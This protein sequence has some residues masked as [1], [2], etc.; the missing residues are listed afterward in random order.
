MIGNFVKALGMMYLR[1]RGLFLAVVLMAVDQVSKA[2][3]V[4]MAQSRALPVVLHHFLNLV[5]VINR[6]IS[7]GI[8]AHME[9]WMSMVL[10]VG[11]S[12]IALGLTCWLMRAR[13]ATLIFGLAFVIGGALG[14]IVDRIRFGFVIDFLDFH[15]GEYHY[16][17]FNIADSFIFMGVVILL[18]LSIVKPQTAL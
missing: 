9:S 11:T 2:A 15:W 18:L 4:S 7:F 14:N 13:D 8:F 16:P 12:I 17:A 5:V 3:I 1:V 10:T 6:G